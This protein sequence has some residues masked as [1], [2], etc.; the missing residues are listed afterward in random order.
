MAQG[1]D[2]HHTCT[3][4][5][6]RF[7]NWGLDCW[8]NCDEK[9]GRCSFCG[10]EG[11]CC[12]SDL[13]T[14]PNSGR[15]LDRNFELKYNVLPIFWTD[16]LDIQVNTSFVSPFWGKFLKIFS[17]F[18]CHLGCKYGSGI[19]G[20][21]TCTV[22]GAHSY[23]N[24]GEECWDKCGQKEG[25]CDF[26]GTKGMCCRSDSFADNSGCTGQGRSGDHTCTTDKGI[27][28]SWNW[29]AAAVG[30]K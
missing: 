15:H 24:D 20:H 19:V 27:Y 17:L 6:K 25:R 7:E 5:G 2:G 26:C 8:D 14:D 10:H 30:T 3:K 4:V 11:D 21:H 12:R 22:A 13:I 1:I 29:A 16:H 18:N 9:E 23:A 28:C